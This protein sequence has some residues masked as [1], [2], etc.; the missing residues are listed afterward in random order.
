D[1]DFAR[2]YDI[3]IVEVV[4]PE[5]GN[6]ADELEEAYEETGYI[7]NSGDFDGMDSDRAY[8][9]IGEWLKEKGKGEFTVNFKLQ[10]WLISRQRYWGAPIPMIHCPDCGVV[11]VP[12]EDLPVKLPEVDFIG[13]K[14]LSAIDE[15]VET[16]CPECGAEARRE[17]DTMDTFVDS[18]WYY[19]RYISAGDEERIFDSETVNDWLPVDQYVGGVEH[20]ILHLL[21]SRFITKFLE[22][23]DLI[24]F[25]EPFERLFTQGMISHRAYRCPDHGWI[26][27]ENV[28]EGDRCPECGEDLKVTMESMSK[29][30]K[31]V[32]SPKKLIDEYGADTERI[33]T[34][35]IGPPEK[36]VEWSD[37][38]VKGSHRFLT[39]VWRLVTQYLDLF[40]EE[41]E[42][43]V[44][45]LDDSETELWRVVNQTVKEVTEDL[46]SFSFN[47]AVSSIM[48]LT[49]EFYRV[50][51]DGD[52][53]K[54]LLK[55]S[56]RK[57]VL[58]TSPFT[59]FIGEE[60]WHR[61]GNDYP[62]ADEVWPSWD[63]EA[64][65]EDRTE[66]AVQINGKVRAHLEVPAD[67]S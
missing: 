47:T 67:I 2:K 66:L 8:R 40:E 38:D 1:F 31:N 16:T 56:I 61:M 48:E 28:E 25:K 20:A 30:K 12:E 17:T 39:R 65:Q 46:E 9:E 35:F 11:P 15:F 37:R 33:Y 58:I 32:V 50:I 59:P 41:H 3:P 10:D 5:K 63:E 7:V 6:P 49:N 64:L 23:I 52:T 53:D 13:S 26:R 4:A 60:L 43:N 57:L 19:L 22:D 51:S 24:D 14:G 34:L 36:D 27:P 54:G 62:V 42:L 55:E 44:D 45:E 18:S 21:Y 29:S